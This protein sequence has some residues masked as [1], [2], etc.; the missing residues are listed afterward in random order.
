MNKLFSLKCTNIRKKNGQGDFNK[1][2]E[3][4]ILGKF[5]INKSKIYNINI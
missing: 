1:S 5:N 4:D 3:G 2:N